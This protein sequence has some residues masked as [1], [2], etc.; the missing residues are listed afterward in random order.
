VADAPGE[1]WGAVNAA[2][3][4]GSRGLPG[5]DTLAR[6]L[7]RRLGLGVPQ[8]PDVWTPEEDALVRGL[9]PAEAARRTGRSVGAVYARRSRLNRGRP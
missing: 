8:R 3:A 7:A 4:H 6:L 5:G 1:T 9:P 2:L